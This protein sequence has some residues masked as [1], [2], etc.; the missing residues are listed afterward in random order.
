MVIDATRIKK[1][2]R[3]AQLLAN[4]VLHVQVPEVMRNVISCAK[5]YLRK[6]NLRDIKLLR[7]IDQSE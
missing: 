6:V 3:V 7:T 2:N 4:M 5:V 1:I